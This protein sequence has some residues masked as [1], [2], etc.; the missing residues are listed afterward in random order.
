MSTQILATKLYIPPPR[1]TGVLRS[2]LIKRLNQGLYRKLTL[3][4]AP[5]GF[6]KT[7]LLASWLTELRIENEKLRKRPEPRDSQFSILNSQFNVAWL[8]IDKGDSD[9]ARFLT[10]LVAALQT[11][12]PHIGEGVSE[13][14][15]SP[16]PPPI[17]S[18]L[19]S[20]LNEISTIPDDFI[21]VLDDYHV[22]DSQIS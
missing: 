19:T 1:P 7:T 20:L 2:R 4:S 18:I 21:L 11:I 8:S 13:M 16:Q 14:L 6:G 10:Y 22:L 17:E 12:V 3:L 9:P 15:K 5:A